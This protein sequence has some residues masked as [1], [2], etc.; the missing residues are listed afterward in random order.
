MKRGC[1]NQFHKSS[2]DGPFSIFSPT[3]AE[4]PKQAQ[5]KDNEAAHLERRTFESVMSFV[6]RSM[7]QIARKRRRL[8]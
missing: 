1:A 6:V 7:R 2:Q 8:R 5:S 4:K 3:L